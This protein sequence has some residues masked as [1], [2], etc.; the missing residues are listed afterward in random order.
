M[1]RPATCNKI[2][3]EITKL[4]EMAAENG[5]QPVLLVSAGIRPYFKQIVERAFARL[6]CLS[7][8]EVVS[9][10]EIQSAGVIPQEV[11]M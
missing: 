1:I 8:N 10:V 6:A 9:D 4:L 11:L 7:F 2:I 3:D 5:M